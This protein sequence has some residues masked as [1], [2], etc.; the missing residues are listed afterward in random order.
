M[1][2]GSGVRGQGL[3]TEKTA[4]VFPGQGSQYVGMGQELLARFSAARGVFEEASS[5]LHKD[6][7]KLCTEG[8]DARLNLTENT[9][10][11]ILTLSVALWQVLNQENPA[12]IP[13]YL[14]GHSLGEYTALVVSGAMS[15]KD[16]VRVVNARGRFMQEAVPERV[17]AMA[18]VLGLNGSVVSNI[19]KEVSTLTHVV[20]AANFN[21]PE[22][23]VISGNKESVEKASL[24]AKEK[25]AK[26]V[27]PLPVSVPSHSPLMN[28]AA[29]RL[30]E[31]LAT[32][33][34]KPLNTPVITNVE[35]EPITSPDRV[36]ELLVSQLYSPVRWVD[37]IIKMKDLG[38]T[39]I[40]E[41]GP[42]KVLTGLVKRIDS[43]IETM[44]VEKAEDVKTV[45]EFRS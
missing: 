1:S 20:V 31:E 18:A 25:G 37:T 11:A 9:Q 4:F 27:I 16:A 30:K 10:P 33:D 32:V 3:K 21:S 8:D 12:I 34:I 19:C 13:L 23:T 41:I 2:Q 14:A 26:R 40:I 39:K 24:V 42:S 44:N 38:I 7:V 43:N 36:K 29:K 6:M 17:G 45:G 22:Q 35:A 28:P 15:F 5:V